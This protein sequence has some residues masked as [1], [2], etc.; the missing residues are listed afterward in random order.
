MIS[1]EGKWVGLD[2]GR[3][4]TGFGLKAQIRLIRRLEYNHPLLSIEVFGFNSC[5]SDWLGGRAGGLCRLNSIQKFIKNNQQFY[6]IL[7]LT[8][9]IHIKN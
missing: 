5:G 1:G 7:D 3:G 8:L 6:K 9:C 2:S 4:W